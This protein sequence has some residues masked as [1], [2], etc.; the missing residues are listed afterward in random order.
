MLAPIIKTVIE[1][2]DG[3]EYED[4]NT[5]DVSPDVLINDGI[6]SVPTLILLKDDKEVWRHVGLLSKDVI[7][8]NIKKHNV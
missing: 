1:N 5:F 2:I 7:I 6:R 8:E 3:L 4:I